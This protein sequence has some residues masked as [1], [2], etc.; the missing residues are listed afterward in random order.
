LV[1]ALLIVKYKEE[2][3]DHPVM[4]IAIGKYLKQVVLIT[5]RLVALRSTKMKKKADLSITMIVAVVI[6]LV[7]LL[8]VLGITTGRL[9]LFGKTTNS[10][11]SRGGECDSSCTSNEVEIPGTSC[12]DDGEKCCQKVYDDQILTP[13]TTGQDIPDTAGGLA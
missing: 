12:T 3:V 5:N 10:C 6:A 1:K 13:K 11:P 8:V 9:K 2:L 7:L 4:E